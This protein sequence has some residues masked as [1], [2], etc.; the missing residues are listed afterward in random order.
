MAAPGGQD[1]ASRTRV[2]L[3]RPQAM[4]VATLAGL[5]RETAE[6]HGHFEKTHAEHHWWDWYA[7]Y[8]SARESDSNPD[9]AA[10]AANRYMEEVLHV[11]P[12]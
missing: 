7:Q 6:Q 12:L 8:M 5:L 11:L 2:D 10:A 1:T 9:N 3:T 4:D